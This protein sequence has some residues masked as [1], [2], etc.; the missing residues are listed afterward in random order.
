MTESHT[1]FSGQYLDRCTGLRRDEQRLAGIRDDPATR[2]MPVWD[3]RCL[4]RDHAAARLTRRELGSRL[5]AS[6]QAIFLGSEPAG[7]L[8]AVGI[9]ERDE[10]GDLGPGNFA[11]LRELISD[12]PEREAALLA[13]ARAM[14]HWH[15]RHRHCGMCGAPNA[16]LEGGFVLE[17]SSASCRH[18]SFP[19][20]DPAVIVLVHAEDRCLLGRQSSWPEGRFSTIAGFV[21][22]GESL[23]DAVRR[24]VAEETDI[25]VG[26]CL[27]IASQPWPFPASLMI[28]FHAEPASETIRLNDGELA[29]ARWVSRAAI[30]AGAV[31]LPPQ[32]SVAYRLIEEWF[33]SEPGPRLAAIHHGSAFLRRPE[34]RPEEN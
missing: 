20:L 28:G 14:V 31:I 15:R 13:Y 16:S 10:P 17:C 30:A 26:H 2:F 9:D 19:R 3:E 23:E 7:H 25:R 6:H 27:Y 29:E 22:P 24:E 18:R 8:F 1:Y 5:P 33:D 12:L 34:Q 21:E 4:V 32:A 11:G